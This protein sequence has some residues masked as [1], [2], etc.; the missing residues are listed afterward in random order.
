MQMGGQTLASVDHFALPKVNKSWEVAFECLRGL[1]RHNFNY[2]VFTLW[3]FRSQAPVKRVTP[4]AQA[5]VLA[6]PPQV[7]PGPGGLRTALQP[8]LLPPP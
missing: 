3:N 4:L 8:P 7:A 5:S 1:S 6:K 2:A